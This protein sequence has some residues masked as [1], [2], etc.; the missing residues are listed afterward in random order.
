M[1]LVKN[2]LKL[3]RPHVKNMLVIAIPLLALAAC[4]PTRPPK[5]SAG[6]LQPKPNN[7]IRIPQTVRQSPVVPL[8]A[9]K[10][11][12]ETYTVVVSNVPVR[13]L[14]FSLARDAKINVDIHPEITG[15]VSINAISQTL[16]QILSRVSRQVNIRYNI[17]DKVISITP[18]KPYWQ[19]YRIDYVNMS[20]KSTSEV[21]VATQIATAGGSVSGSGTSTSKGNSSKTKLTNVSS[22]D[23]WKTIKENLKALSSITGDKKETT[24]VI[25]NA[26]SGIAS[27]KTTQ[28]KHLKV[29][30]FI[31][32][33]MTNV[34]RQVLIEVTIVEVE[35]GNRFQAGIDWQRLS[36]GA[37][38]GSNGISVIS[39][40][41]GSN[42]SAAPTFSLGYNRTKSN[43]SNI[44]STMKLL[45]SFGKVKVISSPKIMALNNQTALLKVVD[46]KVYF[47]VEL[48]I[49]VATTT[50]PERRT[51]TSKIHTIP[52]GL[53]MTV[54]PQINKDGYVSLNIRPTITRITGFA[55]DPAPALMNATFTNL[56]PEIQIREM[57]SLLQV[58]D[59]QTIMMGGLMQNK[60][61]KKTKSLPGLSKYKRINKLLSYRDHDFTKTELVIFIRPTIIKNG[62]S[63]SKLYGRYLST[64]QK[65][66]RSLVSSK[67]K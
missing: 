65:H 46:E 18:D 14:L 7:N 17:K 15:N 1:L 49:Q 59:G 3:I 32:R 63:K 62:K 5:L 6:H 44:S 28:K 27:V 43:G 61:D 57:E 4:N 39:N 41:I 24:Q 48:E 30:S 26:T 51:F 22:N 66:K 36:S 53:V 60:I 42:L 56:I 33:V 50:S 47:T 10:I 8:P 25:I 45:E 13:E 64:E 40:L 37:G 2:N 38:A 23:F 55:N 58:S 31:D 34:Q 9:P 21:S 16:P 67:R 12:E 11:K 29:Q 52:V 19:N 54:V 20:R 35:L